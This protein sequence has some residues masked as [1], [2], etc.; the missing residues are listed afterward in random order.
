M[1]LES[2]FAFEYSFL[3]LYAI[4]FMAVLYSSVGHGG[5]SGYL[6]AMALWGL[7]KG[8]LH[9]RREFCITEANSV[10]HKRIL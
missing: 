8:I 3:L 9:S 10:L 7:Q 2:I 4:A 1:V 6:A 5:A